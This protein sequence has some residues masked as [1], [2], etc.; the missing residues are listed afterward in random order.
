MRRNVAD[1]FGIKALTQYAHYIIYKYVNI[2][3][4][5]KAADV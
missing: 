2:D 1:G 3:T 5:R 4:L